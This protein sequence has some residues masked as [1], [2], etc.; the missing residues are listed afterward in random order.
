MIKIHKNDSIIDIITKIKN[1]KDKEIV[2]EFPFWHPVLHN[3]TSLKILK[4]KAEKKEL[5]IIT[6]DKT[7][8]KIWKTLWIKYSISTNPDLIEHN[9]SFWEY[10]LYTFKNYFREIKDLFLQKNNE[11]YIKIY[12]KNYNKSKIWLFISFLL[13]SFVLLIFIFYFAVNK[14]YVYITPEIQVKSK[15][16]NFIFKEIWE[17]ETILW[18]NVIKVEKITK[19]VYLDS[20]FGSTGISE[21]TQS[22]SRWKV[23]IYNKFNEDIELLANSRIQDEN[24]TVFTLEWNVKIPK[25]AITSTWA[26][27]PWEY[28]W[29]AKSTAKSIWWEII[30]SKANIWSGTFLYFPKLESDKDKLYWYSLDDFKWA[31]DN[32]ER[33]ITSQDVENAK[34]ILREKL[35][36]ESLKQLKEEINEKNLNSDINQEIIWINWIIEYSNFSVTWLNNIKLWDKKDSFELWW[37]IRITSYTYNKDFL[38]NKLKNFIKETILENTEEL[39]E[40]DERSLVVVSPA[41]YKDTSYPFYMKATVQINALFMH[42][43]DNI[44]NNYLYKLKN[45]IAW[46]E[47][48]EA[49]KILL[50]NNTISNAEVSIRPFFIDKVSKITENIVFKVVKN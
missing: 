45:M 40:I 27:I 44:N 42:D 8:R 33:F 7:A 17:N 21:E 15:A 4:T 36:T 6:N 13:F 30:W 46:K 29:F 38:I 25:A 3:F 14:T 18:D 47:K 39:L 32:Y 35:E 22:N 11:E 24:W 12:K 48:D 37:S 50:N 10:F 31:D 43:F 26:V 41:L 2:L 19:L 28:T 34:S 20:L 23:V 5:I 49:E 9:Y 1:S 16:K